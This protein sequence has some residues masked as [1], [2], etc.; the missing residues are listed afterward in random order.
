MIS[1]F[2][3]NEFVHVVFFGRAFKIFVFMFKKPSFNVVRHADIHYP[4][5]PVCEYIDII[6]MVSGHR[7]II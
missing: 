5:V 2:K 4:V 6:I 3:V 7:I 1:P